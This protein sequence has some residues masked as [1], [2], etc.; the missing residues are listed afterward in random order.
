M[1]FGIRF[2]EKE[3]GKLAKEGEREREGFLHKKGEGN[4]AFKGLLSFLLLLLLLSSSSSSS[5]LFSLFIL[6]SLPFLI[7]ILK[8][9]GSS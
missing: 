5:S 7:I 6:S 1:S 9:D 4:T 3:L 8:Q 2:N